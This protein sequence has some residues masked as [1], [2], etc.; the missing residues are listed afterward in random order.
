MQIPSNNKNKDKKFS[1][2]KQQWTKYLSFHLAQGLYDHNP[3]SKI[4]KSYMNSI[5]CTDV[6]QYDG[7]AMRTSYC[8]NRWCPTCNRIRTAINIIR[9]AEQISQFGQPHFVTLTRPTCSL[10]ELPEQIKAMEASWRAMYKY[11]KDKRKEP[12]K[13]GVR[14]IGIRKMECTLRPDGKYHYHFHLIVEGMNNAY[15]IRSEWLKRNPDADMKA[16]DIRTADIRSLMEVF[17]YQT[18]AFTN[19]GDEPDYKRLNDL[20]EVMRGKRT[21]ALFGG[22]K[23]PKDIEIE[24]FEL[25]AQK[26]EELQIRLGNHASTWVWNGS[27][28]DWVEKETGELL[29]NE[30]IPEK[31]RKR[32]GKG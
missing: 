7:E 21:I 4:R 22:L 3:E 23:V 6:K 28:S 32:A 8:K 17:K 26:K 30:E 13:Q 10:E 2:R 20:F 24:D 25:E 11:S 19:T 14:L 18:K 12:Y 27:A 15:W 1:L 29:I 9:Y 5:F 31:I 16:Q